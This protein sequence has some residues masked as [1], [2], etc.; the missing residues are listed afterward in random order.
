M[1]IIIGGRPNRTIVIA[2]HFFP[3][4]SAYTRRAEKAPNRQAQ[5][6]IITRTKG[7]WT[8]LQMKSCL[9]S[10]WRSESKLLPHNCGEGE[11]TRMTEINLNDLTTVSYL[12]ARQL[13]MST[14]AGKSGTVGIM[15]TMS[16]IG[17]L[18]AR[19]TILCISI[20]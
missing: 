14:S 15:R 7:S 10:Q 20:A 11:S 8:Y 2:N 5:C 18:V 13:L 19:F 17:T 6:P 3:F 16:D 12:Y 4:D 9:I 1:R